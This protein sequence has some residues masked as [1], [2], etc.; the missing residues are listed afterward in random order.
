MMFVKVLRS[1]YEHGRAW[2]PM[3]PADSAKDERYTD[4]DTTLRIL[5][6]VEQDSAQSQRALAGEAEVALGL[7]NAYLKRC[8]RK[9][10]I[11]VREAP[12]RRFF[13][14]VTPKGFTEKARLTA[15]YLSNS[16]DMFRTARGQCDDL[17]AQCIEKGYTR[18]ALVGASDFAEIAVLSALNGE[19]EI[20]AVVDA[21][22]NRPRLAGI[23][24]VRSLA[25]AE[26]VDTVIITD[27]RSPQATYDELSQI[28]PDASILTP[29]LLR[30]TRKRQDLDRGEAA[31]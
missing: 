16:F 21:T 30:V 2:A 20:V 7:A 10:W 13:Y 12:A 31:E 17:M 24:V 14:Y 1:R 15:E 25:E 28:L 18:I 9:G 29:P 6:A 27:I 5:D 23:P 11:K 22:S 19:V 4:T 8:V 3:N 26:A